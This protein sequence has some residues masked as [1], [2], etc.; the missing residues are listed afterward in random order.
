VAIDPALGAILRD[1]TLAILEFAG[2][3]FE[4]ARE[5]P[6]DE[7]LALASTFRDAFVV[8]DAIGWL[9]ERQTEMVQVTI[10]AA[11]VARLEQ[12]RAD[13]GLRVFDRLAARHESTSPDERAAVDDQ[14]EADRATAEGLL[15]ILRACDRRIG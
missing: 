14:I 7:L 2:G 12:L 11:H 5:L 3:A 9:A 10:T 13:L 15:E 8:L 1:Q 6:P 4:G